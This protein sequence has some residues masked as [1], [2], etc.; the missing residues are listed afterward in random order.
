MRALLARACPGRDK[1]M[2]GRGRR[3]RLTAERV[4]VQAHAFPSGTTSTSPTARRVGVHAL[5][6]SGGI[7]SARAVRMPWWAD[8]I[9]R[10]SAGRVGG[11]RGA[12]PW[13]G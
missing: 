9:R 12:G 10:A 8:G 4:E 5:A 11:R 13:G 3:V 7:T 6:T 2:P 1:G